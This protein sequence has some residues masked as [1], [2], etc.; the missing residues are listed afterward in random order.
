[1]KNPSYTKKG[2][3]RRHNHETTAWAAKRIARENEQ[4][5]AMVVGA[6]HGMV[7]PIEVKHG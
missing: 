6:A 2:P 5:R 3:G 7:S 4:R 1:M